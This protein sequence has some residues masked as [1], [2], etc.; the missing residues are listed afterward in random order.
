[1]YFIVV[2]FVPMDLEGEDGFYDNMITLLD[3]KMEILD[4]FKETRDFYDLIK[5]FSLSEKSVCKVVQ[6]RICCMDWHSSTAKLLLSV[7]DEEG[8]IGIFMFFKCS[9]D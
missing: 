2:G 6:S 5:N 4:S 9:A 7:G 1:M 3:Q 8:N